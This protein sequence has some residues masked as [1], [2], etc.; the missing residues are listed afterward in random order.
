LAASTTPISSA[1][2][3]VR[4]RL[5]L[6][7]ILALIG[8]LAA[9]FL[10]LLVIGVLISSTTSIGT[11][12]HVYGEQSSALPATVKVNNLFLNVT[13][14]DHQGWDDIRVQIN[15]AY[16]CRRI[17]HL[18]QRQ[19]EELGLAGCIS[20]DGQ[21]FNPRTMATVRV[22]VTATRQDDKREASGSFQLER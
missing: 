9:G 2:E 14:D 6:R 8:V 7:H 5:E 20:A 22:T 4:K 1:P 12:P 15:G 3:R 21:R 17:E 13:N 11:T 18:F 16:T 10:A 19:T